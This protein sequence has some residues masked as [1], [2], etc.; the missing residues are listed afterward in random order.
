MLAIVC[1]LTTVPSLIT[2]TLSVLISEHLK[3]LF[4]LHPW[5]GG[6]LLLRIIKLFL[7]RQ[8]LGV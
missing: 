2:S 5:T 3:Y 1:I 6:V 8:P 7:P 4:T